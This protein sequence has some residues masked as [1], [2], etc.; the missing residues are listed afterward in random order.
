MTKIIR[1]QLMPSNTGLAFIPGVVLLAPNASP[2]L[3]AHELRHKDQQA[4]DGWLLWTLRYALSPAWRL[5]YE[6]EAYAV[7]A[8]HKCQAAD[9]RCDV[10]LM[11]RN[12]ADN[13]RYYNWWFFWKPSV[14]TAVERIT[15]YFQIEKLNTLG[16]KDD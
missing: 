6:A 16:D 9:W 1:T 11:I 7:S 12:E 3:E 5:A 13:L 2:S 10:R 8:M 14:D 4:R 15:H